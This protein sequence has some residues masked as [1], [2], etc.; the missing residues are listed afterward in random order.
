MYRNKQILIAILVVTAIFATVEVRVFA[1]DVVQFVTVDELKTKIEKNERITIL[2]VRGGN[3]LGNDNKVKG[4]IYVRLRKL[5][6]R[7]L[8]PPLK[9]VPK[10]QE[11]ITY[12]AC[13][14]DEASIRAAKLLS[15]SGFTR[16]RVLKGGWMEW[17]RAKGAV[18]SMTKVG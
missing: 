12:C 11:I 17:K 15:D 4:A 6:Q 14:N 5:K 7:L 13:P 10:S 3:D 9:D 18:E 8:M 1:D 2:D 16:V